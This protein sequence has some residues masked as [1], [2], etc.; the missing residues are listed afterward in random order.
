MTGED[1]LTGFPKVLREEGIKNGVDAGVA[2]GQAV[3]HDA[4]HKG[5][6]VQREFSK[7][8]PHGNYMMGHPAEE[9]CCDNQQHGLSCLTERDTHRINFLQHNIVTYTHSGMSGFYI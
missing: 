6:I 9:E 8:H 4:E 1:L 3:R 5:G 7:F 2:V